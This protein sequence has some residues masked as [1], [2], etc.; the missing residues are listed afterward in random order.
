MNRNVTKT[1]Q[2]WKKNSRQFSLDWLNQALHNPTLTECIV[3]KYE[4][5]SLAVFIF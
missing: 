3:E 1:L 2:N 4:I 5:R